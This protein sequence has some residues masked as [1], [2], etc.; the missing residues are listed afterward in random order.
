MLPRNSWARDANVE[1]IKTK[2]AASRGPPPAIVRSL[3]I[4]L[5][6][7]S[8]R[9]TLTFSGSSLE[10]HLLPHRSADRIPTSEMHSNRRIVS[11]IVS[12]CSVERT[13]RDKVL[14]LV[15][16]SSSLAGLGGVPIGCSSTCG[17]RTTVTSR[18]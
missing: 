12:I 4:S 10:R 6:T 3:D 15:S 13:A 14:T 11:I 8:S 17:D 9:A 7:I 16:N 2:M 5:P 1:H 18:R